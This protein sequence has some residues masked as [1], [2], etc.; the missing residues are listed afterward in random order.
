[1][2]ARD[3]ADSLTHARDGDALGAALLDLLVD[4]LCERLLPVLE[5]V[6]AEAAQW[7]LLDLDE[8]AERLGRSTRWV[9]ERVKR[10]DL[11]HVKLDGGALAFELA[12]LQ[13]FADARRVGD[14]PLAG[15]LHPSRDPASVNGS[16]GPYRVGHRRVAA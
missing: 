3:A 16:R 7:R 10:G 5:P 15:R 2:T 8:A 14:K 13:A 11:P 9:R 6:P 12:D 1:V 4:R